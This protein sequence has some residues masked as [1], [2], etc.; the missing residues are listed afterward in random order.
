[1]HYT[2]NLWHGLPV[3]P[4]TVVLLAVFMMLTIVGIREVSQV[5]V[6]IFVTHLSAMALLIVAGVLFV[7]FNG[8][9]T[10]WANF[11]LP[12]ERGLAQALFSGFAAAML[13]I[14][15]FESSANFVEEQAEGVFTKTL[16]NMWIA[17]S[18]LNPAMVISCPGTDPDF[19]RLPIIRKRCW[20]I[21]VPFR[22]ATGWGG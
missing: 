18:V 11:A 14:S 17:V 22:V 21:W 3:I 6:A 20:L 10:L 13:G 19:L 16:R 7:A 8:L 9:E 15:G 5:A 12:A 2:H 4:A 1:M